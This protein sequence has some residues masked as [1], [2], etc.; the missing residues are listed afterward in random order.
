MPHQYEAWCFASQQN[1]T[2]LGLD[3]GLGKT[4]VA[5][6]LLGFYGGAYIC[7]PF[8]VQN[9][10]EELTKWLPHRII[11]ILGESVLGFGDEEIIIVPDSHLPKKDVYEHLKYLLKYIAPR[12]WLVIDEAH[13]FKNKEAQRTQ[14]LLGT[15]RQKG[16]V[17]LFPYHTY[18]SGTPM[19]NRPIELYPILAKAAPETIDFRSEFQYGL[20]YCAG[21]KQGSYG[22]NF[23]G[24]SNVKELASKVIAPK[25]PFM[26]R[27][28]KD[29]LGLPPKTESVFILSAAPTKE[30]LDMEKALGAKYKSAEDL[31][32]ARIAEAHSGDLHLGTYRRL[33]GLQKIKPSVQRI[34]A[35]LEDTDQSVLVFAYHG[36]VVR[37][38]EE[39]LAEYLPFVVSGKTSAHLRHSQVQDFQK[40]TTRRVF[41]GNYLALGVGFTLTKASR[42]F[43]VEYDWSPGNN[44]QA[45]DRAHRI[46][47]TKPVHVEYLVYKD[48][49]DKKIIEVLLEKRKNIQHV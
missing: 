47:Q 15:K 9:V 32:K 1:R 24:A 40:S 49:I 25:G 8:L 5:A 11:G 20:K 41:I 14:V 36:E 46:G 13:R 43:F 28:R 30:L 33:L 21:F 42:V 19:P 23:S 48:S 17:D 3:P 22:W 12:A 38:L 44:D 16:I 6:M 26:L 34:R 37:L 7:P 27:Q 18:M 31:I 45:G 4:V 10:Y 29:L 2:Y 35:V 39:A